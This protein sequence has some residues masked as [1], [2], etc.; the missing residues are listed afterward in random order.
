M[1]V[2]SALILGSL[3]AFPT[4]VASSNACPQW[5]E[6]LGNCG[7][8]NTGTDII[9]D[10]TH[11][12]GGTDGTETGPDDWQVPTDPGTPQGP[13]DLDTC[14]DDWESD[15]NCFDPIAENEEEDEDPGIPPVT[16]TDLV[17]FAP[18]GS[19]LTGEPN[20]VGVA[21]LPT[22]F[23]TAAS[24]QTVAGE[25]FGFPLSVRFTPAAYD[26]I[27]GDG[28]TSTSSTGGATW[29]DLAQV[30]FTPTDTSHAYRERGTYIAQ[31]NVRYSAEVD[32]GTGW[33]PVTGQVTANGAPQEIRIFEAHTA[34]VAF[35]CAEAPHSP[36]C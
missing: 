11:E 5:Q 15:K 29:A 25:L 28:A 34:L 3:I 30:Q 31:V 16:I 32:F 4:T 13:S 26:F 19:V 10:G 8:D 14:L 21:G 9:I 33:F 36:G 24:T 35:T 2:L 20:N 17:R 22:N 1:R 27:Y 23:V 6:E 7:V 18:A 12:T